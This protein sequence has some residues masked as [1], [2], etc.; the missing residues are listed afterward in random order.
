MTG[1]N[2]NILAGHMPNERNL[3][4]FTTLDP[5]RTA[6]EVRKEEMAKLLGSAAKAGDSAAPRVVP[7]IVG[8]DDE[9]GAFTRI[10]YGA[11]TVETT[12]ARINS[13]A[14]KFVAPGGTVDPKVSYIIPGGSISISGGIQALCVWVHIADVT[15]INGFNV[16][17]FQDDGKFLSRGTAGGDYHPQTLVNGWNFLRFS[18][19]PAWKAGWDGKSLKSIDFI[20]KAASAVAPTITIGQVYVE[21]PQMARMIFVLDRGYRSFILNG[22]L[23]DLR[24][25][26]IPVTWAIDV[27]AMGGAVGT[28]GEAITLAEVRDMWK[29]GDSVSFHGWDGAVTGTMTDSQRVIDTVKAIKYLASQGY[30]GRMWRAAWVQNNGN[31]SAIKEYV[32]GQAFSNPSAPVTFPQ[33]SQQ[34]C[35][36]PLN[37]HSIYR[38]NVS[39]AD[40]AGGTG[41]SK[42]FVDDN[43]A[44]W[45]ASRGLMVPYVHG[46]ENPAALGPARGIPAND[47]TIPKWKYFMSKVETALSEGWLLP[48]TFEDS[49]RSSGGTFSTTGGGSIARW[50]DPDGTSRTKNLL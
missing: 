45:K 6:N 28:G 46:I 26:S 34:E 36:P 31:A 24:R 50:T 25:N 16:N 18:F 11:P 29:Q 40:Y 10:G 44:A 1:Y 47:I 15:G 3:S 7:I 17:V 2:F 9:A 35:W 14:W 5:A 30:E 39:G 8:S 49:W 33:A 19:G 22:G 23:A 13:R 12:N 48:T 4:A 42:T 37:I 32:L 43:F 27:T 21:S 20:T 41:G 38:W